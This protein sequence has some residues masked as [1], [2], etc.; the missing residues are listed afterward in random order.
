MSD[1]HILDDGFAIEIEKG[2]GKG[3]SKAQKLAVT[4]WVRRA[5]VLTKPRPVKVY[6]A[7]AIDH[8]EQHVVKVATT[9]D[10]LKRLGEAEAVAVEVQDGVRPKQIV[11]EKC[12]AITVIPK[13]GAVPK[14]CADCFVGRCACG[15]ALSGRRSVACWTCANPQRPGPP[16]IDC[17]KRLGSELNCP[18]RISDRGGRPFRCPGCTA[19]G[20]RIAMARCSCGGALGYSVNAA[21]KR[22]VRLGRA[23]ACRKCAGALR[24][25]RAEVCSVCSGAVGK[26]SAVAARNGGVAVCRSCWVERRRSDAS[27]PK[28]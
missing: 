9:A 16:C 2:E 15:N 11:C 26:S 20:K 8:W 18:K 14:W 19:I 23:P 17:G 24:R 10:A 1:E 3:M 5:P 12:G 28:R 25:S 6:D 22:E 21:A 27:S 13:H 7:S 4:T